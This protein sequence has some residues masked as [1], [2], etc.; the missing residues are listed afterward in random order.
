MQHNGAWKNKSTTVSNNGRL[1]DAVVTSKM[2]GRWL[3]TMMKKYDD[4]DDV[5]VWIVNSNPQ[6]ISLLSRSAVL[7]HNS[8]GAGD[9]AIWRQMLRPTG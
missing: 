1:D 7:E 2:K 6:L 5:I 9:G 3:K 4:D 8:A